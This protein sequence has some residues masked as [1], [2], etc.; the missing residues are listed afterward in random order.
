[1]EEK[2]FTINLRKSGLKTPRWKKT[3]KAASTIREYL[4]KHM[5]AET[6]KIGDSIN[7]QLWSIGDQKPPGKLKIKAIKT[8][9]GIVKAELFGQVFEEELKE[10]TKKPEE[11]KPEEKKESKEQFKEENQPN[12]SVNK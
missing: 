11:K 7:K 3:T 8:D 2:V 5:K 1:M 10:E 9:D 6:V 4:K 12:K